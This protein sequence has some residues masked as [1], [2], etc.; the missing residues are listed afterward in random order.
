MTDAL[1]ITNL[2]YRYGVFMD[3]GDFDAAAELLAT[4]EVRLMGGKTLP[5]SAMRAIWADMIVLHPGG[6]PRTQHVIT[7]PI[8]DIDATGMMARCQSCY[9]VLQ[10]AEGFPLQIIAAGRYDDR[11]VKQ[12]GVWRFAFR[13]YS[14]FLFQG[15]LSRHLRGQTGA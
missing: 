15:D 13:D 9:T 2:L 12:D 6:S 7:N 11:F 1:A 5:G 3:A 14:Q 4:A 8:V 10:Q